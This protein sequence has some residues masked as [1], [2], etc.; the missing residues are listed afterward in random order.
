[1]VL[2]MSEFLSLLV[3][4]LV[5]AVADSIDSAFTNYLS[6]DA[7]VAMTCY[8][9]A[10]KVGKGLAGIPAYTYRVTRRNEDKTVFAALVFSFTV[11][12]IVAVT[13]GLIVHLFAVTAQQKRLLHL[14]LL[15]EP[16]YLV[17]HTLDNAL[18]EITR[19]RGKL[20]LYNRSMMVFYTLLIVTD[21]LA[22]IITHS[23]IALH[24][25]T[26][27]AHACNIGVL[28]KCNGFSFKHIDKAYFHD[29][30]EYGLPISVERL[31]TYTAL[32]LYTSAASRLPET[33]YA[34]HAVCL[35]AETSAECV[36]NA[37]N[38]TLMIQLVTCKNAKEVAIAVRKSIRRYGGVTAAMWCAIF[39]ISLVL[40]HG[41]VPVRDCFPIAFVYASTISGLLVYETYKVGVVMCKKTKFMPVAPLLGYLRSAIVFMFPIPV[42]VAFAVPID[43][44]LRGCYYRFI[45]SSA[46]KKEVCATYSLEKQN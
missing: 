2:C 10:S 11:G 6:V 1:M 26:I 39:G 33:N 38:A 41:V 14:L 19:L 44:L 18:F 8:V 28:L 31:M 12:C 15:L 40:L 16:M 17:A 7:I 45:V 27:L 46:R 4:F 22:Y 13:S 30:R 21:I 3:G 42:V 24:T 29:V 25:T 20:K 35:A 9:A 37:L 34:V 32:M 5:M 43:W 23:V 36:T